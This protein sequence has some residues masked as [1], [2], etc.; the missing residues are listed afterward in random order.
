M[1]SCFKCRC[2]GQWTIVT[3]LRAI[4]LATTQSK[5]VWEGKRERVDCEV[6][7]SDELNTFSS[8]QAK[9]SVTKCKKS[10][11]NCMS[12]KRNFFANV[13]SVPI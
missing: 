1:A 7:H 3:E 6:P 5:Q 12:V 10:Q 8:K 13:E 9:V 4:T 2:S 11:N